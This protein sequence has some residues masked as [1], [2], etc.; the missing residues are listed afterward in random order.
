[1]YNMTLEKQSLIVQTRMNV[2]N[3]TLIFYTENII[4]TK[5]ISNNL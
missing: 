5:L 2:H 3:N 1:M 4:S